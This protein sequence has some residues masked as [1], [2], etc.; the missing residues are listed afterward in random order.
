MAKSFNLTAN[1]VL[2]GPTNLRPIIA[3]IKSALTGIAANVDVKINPSTAGN[4]K[5]LNT[6]FA[7]FNKTLLVTATNSKNAATA[8]SALASAI[9]GVNLKSLNSQLGTTI[10]QVQQVAKVTKSTRTEL[11]E[12]GRVSGLA[13]RR[14]AGFAAS[15]NIL[16]G[17]VGALKGAV[18]E[19]VA[20]Q[21]QMVRLA[22]LAGTST[23]NMDG[24]ART[25]GKLSIDVGISSQKLLEVSDT[26]IQAGLS[27]KDT[28]TALSALAKTM[29]APAFGD[30]TKTVEGM[31]AVMSQFKLTANDMETSLGA[32]NEVAAKFA[33][34]SS[35]LISAVR[36][37]GGSFATMSQ[38]VATGQEALNQF[39]AVFTSVRATTRESAESIATGLRTIFT[40]LERPEAIAQ[41]K[42]LGVE[43]TDVEGKFVGPYEAINRISAAMKNM[44]PRDLRFAQIAES[45]GGY[46]QI[47]K[48][49]PLIQQTE[50]RTKA[51][52]AAQEGGN[53]LNEA[54]A[55]SQ[56]SW[57]VQLQKT[58]EMFVKLIR[59]ISNTSS[60]QVLMGTILQITQGMIKLA[61]A[62]KPIL[63]LI[64]GFAAIKGIS[65]LTQLGTGFM[66]GLKG[67]GMAT[68]GIV[69][70]SGNGDTVPAM[71]T[72]GEFV[73]RK[74]A[75]KAI[76]VEN[77][78]R[79]NRY[80]TGGTVKFG[81]ASLKED[82]DK[83]NPGQISNF[84]K[85]KRKSNMSGAVL[86]GDVW[87]NANTAERGDILDPSIFYKQFDVSDAQPSANSN[88]VIDYNALVA[89]PNI[90]SG[91]GGEIEKS[92]KSSFITTAKR[93]AR[94]ITGGLK[95]SSFAEPG[96][97]GVG[98]ESVI[99]SI[100]EAAIQSIG[101]P[102]SGASN[103][104]KK[105]GATWD[106]PEGLGAANQYFTPQLGNVPVEAKKSIG[107]STA[108]DIK[109]K[110]RNHIMALAS[111]RYKLKPKHVEALMKKNPEISKASAQNK[112]Q[113]LNIENISN[114]GIKKLDKD[115][116]ENILSINKIKMK[117][118]SG[119][120]V[121]D[122]VPAMLTPGE[123]VINK[124][125][126]SRIGPATLHRLNNA[127]R[128]QGFANG[129]PVQHFG[130]G[131]YV[132]NLS[133]KYGGGPSVQA[134]QMEQSLNQTVVDMKAL[135]YEF[136]G[137]RKVAS[138]MAKSMAA[139]NNATDAY[140]QAMK[141]AKPN[142]STQG[143]AKANLGRLQMAGMA[144][145]ALIS[146][147]GEG[148]PLTSALGGI[149]G[150][151][152]A[153][154]AF[155]PWGMAIGGIAGGI[156]AYK[157]AEA[158]KIQ[159]EA[160]K[161]ASEATKE[162]TKALE[163][164]NKSGNI[165]DLEKANKN[166]LEATDASLAVEYNKKISWYE[167]NVKPGEVSPEHLLDKA[168]KD[169]KPDFSNLQQYLR[170]DEKVSLNTLYI[171][172]SH[173][174]KNADGG[175]LNEADKKILEDYKNV[176]AMQSPDYKGR[177]NYTIGELK[178][179]KEYAKD[180]VIPQQTA[181]NKAYMAWQKD[182]A[183]VYGEIAGFTTPRIE[184]LFKKSNLLTPNAREETL[185]KTM[186]D[187]SLKLGLQALA[188]TQGS[189]EQLQKWM[190]ADNI[191]DKQ[192]AFT[193][194]IRD[195]TRNMFI[196]A[197]AQQKLAVASTALTNHFEDLD[198]A[199]LTFSAKLKMI[200]ESTALL[201]T[202]AKRMR[203]MI[204]G[205]YTMISTP[206]PNPFG[207]NAVGYTEA[208]KKAETERI[209]K[210]YY[211][212]QMTRPVS[213]TY[214]GLDWKTRSLTQ[215]EAPTIFG[216]AAANYLNTQKAI[217][218]IKAK[219]LNP[220]NNIKAPGAVITPE[221]YK[222]KITPAIINDFIAQTDVAKLMG[223]LTFRDF[224][225]TGK[226]KE[227]FD[228][229]TKATQPGTEVL[230]NTIDR[231]NKQREER[232][233]RLNEN[234][235]IEIQLRDRHVANLKQNID[236]EN[237]IWQIMNPKREMSDVQKNSIYNMQVGQLAARS[238]VVGTDINSL[239][240]G[241]TNIVTARQAATQQMENTNLPE[242]DRKKAEINVQ[243]LLGREKNITD[244]L[245]FMHS[246]L[247][248]L[249]TINEGMLKIEQ[250]RDASTNT[251][252]DIARMSPEETARQIS[253]MEALR[254]FQNTG[255][256]S[257]DKDVTKI[258]DALNFIKDSIGPAAYTQYRNELA[259]AYDAY[260]GVPRNNSGM[261]LSGTGFPTQK[262]NEYIN[263]LRELAKENKLLGEMLEQ[264]DKT[265][266]DKNR[267]LG[268]TIEQ[269][270]E[271]VFRNII[272]ATDKTIQKIEKVIS[273]M[274]S[275]IKVEVAKTDFGV[276]VTGDT[277]FATNVVKA[278]SNDLIYLI[279]QEIG[280]I[281]NSVDG[282]TN[283]ASPGYNVPLTNPK[284]GGMA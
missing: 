158:A 92:A 261:G 212:P 281:Y 57:T 179:L 102:F 113:A 134:A 76:G 31:I 247:T 266:F 63:P 73:I 41:L 153:G 75:V 71:L 43:L 30:V 173:R 48:V 80:A 111:N 172:Q 129:G 165:K 114:L 161:K 67:K 58:H 61:D 198:K 132:K 25:I 160:T 97:S 154:A 209:L 141:I 85:G 265:L 27:A 270:Q 200:P 224:N 140:T 258:A 275:Q 228:K 135:G 128:I 4:L 108:A 221:L 29:V 191:R 263:G 84:N 252:L 87:N 170:P 186:S 180:I 219:L 34:E 225:I 8:L 54:M 112:I 171:R 88:T 123:F 242:A 178:V 12:F 103:A 150:G 156:M 280:K 210:E 231:E 151:V 148:N 233:A 2:A 181:T 174:F 56:E 194:I 24:L 13:V 229:L 124:D 272:N 236:I 3:N 82:E 249:N 115:V 177:R 203:N 188:Y 197:Q 232:I 5:T 105:Q 271:R 90:G 9:N 149:M 83:Y 214:Y 215:P 273:A 47:G 55:K 125:A 207:E 169:N 91:I 254:R 193:A 131:D 32:M 176:I 241:L 239:R 208:Q 120:G 204:A 22:T 89:Y 110:V 37:A 269:E 144:G 98:F 137:I 202:E 18:Q 206:R 15:T 86:L 264:Y 70:G 253:N 11:E 28:E 187:S 182:L 155:G 234:F 183:P 138:L 64:A 36:I 20:F 226:L 106:F 26:L 78:A 101:A 238:G 145:A 250:K 255:T 222:Q 218:N 14:F 267:G 17:F 69:P 211:S 49:L 192:A 223:D 257:G 74:D 1:L 201:E 116:Y 276:T 259:K 213:G 35:D 220:D 39:M 62:I 190:T 146:Q 237:R 235:N 251:I 104:E 248:R 72:P 277:S 133:I 6:A 122:T 262:E 99:G 246:D 46:R 21:H 45:L 282:S 68:G 168:L 163:T 7:D 185:Q 143:M 162:F 109:Q 152:S 175:T 279:K 81:I 260:L 107:E 216:T 33:V 77:L 50:L 227:F 19:A 126:A 40:R 95:K 240:S 60:F 230:K 243:S 100:F 217:E 127:D 130:I 136:K 189:P 184:S 10:T 121:S 117:K 268:Q 159:E 195:L 93:V 65:A 51:L 157:N 42:Q 244:L 139:G 147:Y 79:A 23:Q 44:D 118:A 205:D 166:M 245:K 164:F 53:S 167:R 196:T 16:M 278:I 284:Y 142:Q 66:A 52:Q 283:P 94:I 59:D 256:V 96:L 119:G 38:G 199:Y 274:P